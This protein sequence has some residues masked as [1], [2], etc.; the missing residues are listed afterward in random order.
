LAGEKCYTRW[1]FRDLILE[2]N[3]DVIQPDLIKAGGITEVKKIAA[4]GQ[5]FF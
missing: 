2:A 3:P 5:A 4:L 1:Q